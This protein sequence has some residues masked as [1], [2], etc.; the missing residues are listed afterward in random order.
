MVLA[1]VKAAYQGFSVGAV[2]IAILQTMIDSLRHRGIQ[3]VLLAMPITPVAVSFHPRG[4]EDYQTA[5]DSF[6]AIAARSG[7][8]FEQPGIWP[9]SLFADPIHLNAAGTAQF[10]S[11]LAGILRS[12]GRPSRPHP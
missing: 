12:Q 1:G 2:N 6:A 7:I 9:T 11:Y 8:A 5:M 4:M 10:T 3:V